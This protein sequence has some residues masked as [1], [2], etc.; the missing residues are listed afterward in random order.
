VSRRVCGREGYELF[1]GRSHASMTCSSYVALLLWEGCGV[2]RGSIITGW[3]QSIDSP[4]VRPPSQFC[5]R[6]MRV[7]PCAR[8]VSAHPQDRSMCGSSKP[9]KEL[10]FSC[11]HL[12]AWRFIF[13]PCL[14]CWWQPWGGP[15][16]SCALGRQEQLAVWRQNLSFQGV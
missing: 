4:C 7:E 8:S 15:K 13:S 14:L 2:A 10:L 5:R 11:A 3:K 1:E 16:V 6:Q 12:L 9:K